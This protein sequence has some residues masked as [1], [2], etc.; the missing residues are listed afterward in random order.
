MAAG[1]RLDAPV[2]RIAGARGRAGPAAQRREAHLLGGEGARRAARRRKLPPAHRAL[3]SRR[4]SR[5]A[6]SAP[7]SSRFM[8]IQSQPTASGC[9]RPRS[10]RGRARRGR[11]PRCARPSR[12]QRAAAPQ[13]R[14]A[15]VV[16]GLRGSRALARVAGVA[17]Q[18]QRL[19]GVEAQRR[20]RSRCAA[21]RA[22]RV[23]V[24]PARRRSRASRQSR[25]AHVGVARSHGLGDAEAGARDALVVA[26]RRCAP[27][28][29]SAACANS[30]WR[31]REA[32]R[33]APA[34][35]PVRE[36][37]KV[38]WKPSRRGAASRRVEPAGDVPPLG[39]VP[40]CAPWSRG[41]AERA[42]RAHARRRRA[43]A[44][45]SGAGAASS[46]A[47][48]RDARSPVLLHRQHRV[49]RRPRGAPPAPRWRVPAS[50][51]RRGQRRQPAARAAQ[52]HRPVEAL[53]VDHVHQHHADGQAERQAEQRAGGRSTPRLRRRRSRAP[54]AR[55]RPRCA[56]RPN[57]LRRASTCAEKLAAMP[58]RP[59]R[60]RHR[61]QPVGDREAA[62]EDAQRQR[63]DLA[64]PARTR[65]APGPRGQ[66]AQPALHARRRRRRGASHSARSLTR[67]S[68]VRRAI[69]ARRRSRPRRTGARSRARRRHE[70]TA[71]RAVAGSGSVESARRA[72]A[73]ERRHRLADVDAGARPARAGSSVADQRQRVRRVAQRPRDQRHARPR[74]VERQRPRAQRARRAPRRAAARAAAT[75]AAAARRCRRRRAACGACARTG[76]PAARCRASA[77]TASRKLATITV[78][79]TARL[80]LATTPATATRARRRAGGAR[81]RSA[82]SAAAAR[83]AR[84]AAG[85]S[86]S[87]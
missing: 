39:A 15:V 87:A 4:R 29:V 30:S 74:R 70:D 75:K 43:C 24:A 78:S 58:N 60:D 38:T 76:R 79:A 19:G 51:H 6:I 23:A 49:A 65:A 27:R 40:G 67:V 53:R 52:L 42:R 17:L 10:I 35:A 69:V 21:A 48:G 3:P 80:R 2:H 25:S 37:K 32:A 28:S 57:S 13:L 36:R 64:P 54:G 12:S 14:L 71:L 44:P 62:V 86:S 41:N 1:R 18:Q 59:M 68:P 83:R 47:A 73:V 66:R 84:R 85:R 50:D 55:V 26:Q 72:R 46:D 45:A 11:A 81:A 22:R 7:P 77:T 9:S 56:S 5:K 8:P 61:L 20:G 63:A 31:A 82:S 34:R 16:A 33:V